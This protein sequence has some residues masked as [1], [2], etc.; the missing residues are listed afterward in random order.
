MASDA[1]PGGAH[2]NRRAA[3]SCPSSDGN[4]LFNLLACKYLPSPG[5]AQHGQSGQRE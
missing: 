3:A 5:N 2:K 4:V 1:W